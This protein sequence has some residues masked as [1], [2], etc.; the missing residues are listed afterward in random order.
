MSVSLSSKAGNVRVQVSIFT[1]FYI[2]TN[3][4]NADLFFI[5]NF[6]P[7]GAVVIFGVWNQLL[8]LIKK[9]P[10]SQLTA[11]ALFQ[12]FFFLGRLHIFCY[13]MGTKKSPKGFCPKKSTVLTWKSGVEKAALFAFAFF[14]QICRDIMHFSSTQ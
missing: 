9:I 11:S 1:H 2:S 12:L 14:L 10:G 5:F 3:Y 8:P 4:Q 7:Q 6:L 13:L